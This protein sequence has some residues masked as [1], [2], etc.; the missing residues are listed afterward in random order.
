MR[1]VKWAIL[2]VVLMYYCA[3]S[4]SFEHAR[5]VPGIH[6]DK[7][8]AVMVGSGHLYNV[9]SC[10]GHTLPRQASY[11]AVVPSIS[12]NLIYGVNPQL[13]FGV[14]GSLEWVNLLTRDPQVP[15]WLLLGSGGLFL[16]LGIQTEHN[17][18]AYKL[19]F[20][21][22]LIAQSLFWDIGD[23]NNLTFSLHHAFYGD[24][25]YGVAQEVSFWVT[26]RRDHT[27]LSLGI[28][29]ATAPRSIE[30]TYFAVGF[31]RTFP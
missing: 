3:S 2:G 16:K 11:L 1:R 25:I 14:H 19:S 18:Y 31:G 24:D 13:G 23:A 12:G 27:A 8:A 20:G 30:H 5:I 10:T 4:P 26:T 6:G 29:H 17:A 22:P 9:T 7:G 15:R 21:M 28:G